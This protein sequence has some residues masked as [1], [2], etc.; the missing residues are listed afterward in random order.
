MANSAAGIGEDQG[1][2][3]D[4]EINGGQRHEAAEEP[5]AGAQQIRVKA[6]GE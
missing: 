5:D 3:T 2:M 1:D 6:R 4:T